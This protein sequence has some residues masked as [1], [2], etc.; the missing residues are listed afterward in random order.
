MKNFTFNTLDE[1]IECYGRENL[2]A[3]DNLRQIIF[4][5][6]NGVQPEFVSENELK[7]GKISCWFHKGKTAIVYH[8]WMEANQK[9]E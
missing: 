9:K 5:T 8:R 7:K 6:A 2:I 3:I 4:Y 1:C